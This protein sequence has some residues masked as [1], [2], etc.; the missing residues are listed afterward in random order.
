MDKLK[1][2]A[3]WVGI[4]AAGVILAAFFGMKVVPLWADQDSLKNKIAGRGG[5][6][7]GELKGYKV[8]GDPDIKAWKAYRQE[9]VKSYNDITKFYSD[10]N[11]RLER[12]FDGIPEAGPANSGDFMAKYRAHKEDLEKKLTDAGVVI[13]IPEEEDPK[14]KFGFNWDEPTIEEFGQIAQRGGPAEVLRVLRELQKRYWARERVAKAILNLS[15]DEKGKIQARVHDFRFFRPLHAGS[16]SGMSYT[17]PTGEHKVSYQGVG[18]EAQSGVPRAFVEYDLR[19]ELGK[20][21]T[22]GFAVELRNSEVPKLLREILNPADEGPGAQRLLVN[23]VG[24]HVTIRGQNPPEVLIRYKQ[25][26]MAE[27][28][29]KE[30]EAWKAVKAQEMMLTVSCQIIDFEPTKVKDFSKPQTP[31]P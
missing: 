7:L 10:S 2:N 6:L 8:P 15:K 13:G 21:L 30:A 23:V 31:A 12:W 26:D 24:T 18:A 4:A 27:K 3:F 19:H 1:Q 14:K 17:A 11:Q 5:G 22:F 20:T 9:M 28:A 25:G 29:A 16:Q